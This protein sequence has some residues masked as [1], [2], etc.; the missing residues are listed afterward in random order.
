MFEVKSVDLSQVI[1]AAYYAMRALERRFS[2]DDLK[3][4]PIMAG[5]ASEPGPDEKELAFHWIEEIEQKENRS[6]HDLDSKTIQHYVGELS[7]TVQQ[8]VESQMKPDLEKGRKLLAL[9]QESV[10]IKRVA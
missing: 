5:L 8:R 2:P 3:K 6:I 7:D 1:G 4:Q 10:P 9:L